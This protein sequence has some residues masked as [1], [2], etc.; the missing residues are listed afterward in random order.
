MSIGS[1]LLE[2]GE[3]L[4]PL[5]ETEA[6]IYVKSKSGQTQL[7]IQEPIVNDIFQALA[8]RFGMQMTPITPSATPAPAAPATVAPATVANTP[9]VDSTSTVQ[10]HSVPAAAPAAPAATAPHLSLGDKV[11]R[12][13]TFGAFHPKPATPSM[14]PK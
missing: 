14:P 9:A 4:I 5:A 13:V 12:D 8:Q 3:I 10:A 2:I 7:S 11:L 1:I 6:N